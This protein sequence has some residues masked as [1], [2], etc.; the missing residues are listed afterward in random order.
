MKPRGVQIDGW[1]LLGLKTLRAYETAAN[2]ASSR[3]WPCFQPGAGAARFPRLNFR[4]GNRT[5][6]PMAAATY[7]EIKNALRQLYLDDPRPWLLGFSGGKDSTMVASL[8]LD[9]VLSVPP[10]QGKKPVAGRNGGCRIPDA[11]S[12]NPQSQIG[13]RQLHDLPRVWVSNPSQFLTTEEVSA[14]LLQKPN[15]SNN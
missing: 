1:S 2:R 3:P 12:V 11:E 4:R 8:V 13:N 5:L 10:D 15:L 7:Q 14:Y 9:A 6:P